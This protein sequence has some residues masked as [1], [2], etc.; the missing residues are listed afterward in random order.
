MSDA[1]GD[2]VVDDAAEDL[3]GDTEDR[4]RNLLGLLERLRARGSWGGIPTG[5]F[6]LVAAHEAAKV[7]DVAWRHTVGTRKRRGERE[8]RKG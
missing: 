5:K 4:I 7:T 3:Y 1:P 6:D 2:A 8:V